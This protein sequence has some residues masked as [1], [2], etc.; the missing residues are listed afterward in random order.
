M[1]FIKPDNRAIKNMVVI[2]AF[3]A[4][5]YVVLY[6]FQ[7]PFYVLMLIYAAAL[8]VLAFIFRAGLC[9]TLAN[10]YY[11]RG[12]KDKAQAMFERSFKYNTKNPIAYLNYSIMTVHG[13]DGA[14][15]LEYAQKALALKPNVMTEKNTYL[16]IGSCYW[17]MGD[18]D[19]AVETLE[20][21][22]ERYDYVNGHVLSTLGYLYIITNKLDKAMETTK[23]AIQESPDSAAAWDNLGQIYLLQD[24]IEKSEEAFLKAVSL[25]DA[26]VDSLYY[27]GII[28]EKKNL[29]DK[30]EEYFFKAYR[31]NIS[32]LNTVTKEQ[33]EEK[34]NYYI[35]R[36]KQ[37]SFEDDDEIEEGLREIKEN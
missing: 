3:L 11:S 34:Y 33:V 36:L 31:C 28:N 15:G 13:G 25:R 37:G 23:K 29:P 14:K 21:M 24:D 19:K 16:T 20:G 18:L 2:A 12:N 10:L 4:V 30:A 26:L 35:D 8:A 32:K 9:S 7:W 27:L 6:V 1:F 17:V 5:Y 22:I